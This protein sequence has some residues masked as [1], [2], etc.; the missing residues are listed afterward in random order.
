M[1]YFLNLVDPERW[2][3][4]L[5]GGDDA[6]NGR[7]TWGFTKRAGVQQGD[8]LVCLLMQRQRW[9]GVLEVVGD[10]LPADDLRVAEDPALAVR[11]PVRT[12][13][14]LPAERAID[15]FHPSIWPSLSTVR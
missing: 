15:V 14:A 7:G 5:S 3:R 6:D 1:G 10:P 9:C 12:A 8:L 4:F 13:V 11:F 2:D